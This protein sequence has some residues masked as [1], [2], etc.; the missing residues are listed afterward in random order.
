M[1]KVFDFD[2][3]TL[4]PN[5]SRVESRTECETSC[6]FG[7]HTFKLPV[8]PANMESIIDVD[9]AIK[10]AKEGYFYI[11]LILMRLHLLK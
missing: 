4:L 8:V 6:K 3:I 11:D 2:N 5:F 10:L 7:D 1:K 9:L